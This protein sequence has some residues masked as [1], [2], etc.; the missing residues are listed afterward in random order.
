MAKIVTQFY[1]RFYQ[2]GVGKL[3]LLTMDNGADYKKPTTFS[4]EALNS[5]DNLQRRGAKFSE[6]GSRFN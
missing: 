2:S 6:P 1:P 3:V 5:L 4:E